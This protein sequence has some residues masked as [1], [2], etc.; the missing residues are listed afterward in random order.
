MI[1]QADLKVISTVFGKNID[2]FSGA[3]SSEEEVSLDLRLNGKILTEEQQKALRESGVQQGK[4]LGSKELAKFLNIELDSG[5]K[6]PAK[7]AEK[8]KTSLS[9]QL[10]EKYKN[11]NPTEELIE[12]SKKLSDWEKKYN[13]LH[14]L[15][16][17][18]KKE[19]DQWK[20][21]YSEKE[22]AER[23]ER[24]NNE[25]L[26]SLPKDISMDRADALLIIK[27]SLKIN[28]EDGK[29][30]ISNGEKTFLDPLGNYETLD[31]VVKSFVE[32]KG[33]IKQQGMGGG[34]RGGQQGKGGKTM[35]PDQ[36]YKYLVEKG[37]P[38]TSPEGIKFFNE[39]V[40]R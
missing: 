5:E 1:S 38:A 29:R 31:N 18:T 25:I 34:D 2:E 16:Q 26:A 39:N 6:E 8:L 9:K 37:I 4:E 36:A 23:D 28:D 12:V 33:W 21:K 15:H 22:L 20:Q 32:T 35:T 13:T 11:M 17:N 27:N 40:K 19:V 3:L 7:L 10:E 30:V 24:V 14:D